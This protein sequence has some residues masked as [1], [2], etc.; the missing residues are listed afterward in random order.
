VGLFAEG[1]L[2]PTGSRWHTAR[3]ARNLT[4]RLARRN[5]PE[6]HSEKDDHQTRHEVAGLP[7]G[8]DVVLEF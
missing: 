6:Q 3:H 1:E 7:F 5:E 2:A 8:K 4:G